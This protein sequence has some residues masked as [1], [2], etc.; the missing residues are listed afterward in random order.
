MIHY[1]CDRCQRSIDPDES[2]RYVVRIDVE[3]IAA[4]MNDTL[5]TDSV[6]FLA[7][8]NET[9]EQESL[10]AAMSADT[11]EPLDY[12]HEALS[13]GDDLDHLDVAFS[14]VTTPSSF[15]S[16]HDALPPSFDLCPQC[17]AAYS[18]NPLSRERSLKLH[19][20][21]N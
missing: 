18:K 14:P 4:T 20:S 2:P 19:F 10:A 17:Y 9:L 5:H 21:N 6:D 7:E 11:D 1:T 13:R 16:E 3:M 15:S 12:L 8:L